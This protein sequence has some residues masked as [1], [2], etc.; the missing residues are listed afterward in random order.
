[1]ALALCVRSLP[2]QE[3]GGDDA[4]DHGRLEDARRAYEQVLA[5][6]SMAFRPNLRVGLMLAW[7]GNRDSA[8]VLIARARRAEPQDV[9]ARLVEARVLGWARRFDDA[10]AR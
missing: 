5:G 10:M 3:P 6:D 2:A 4:W 9:E 1:V 7:Q 8:L